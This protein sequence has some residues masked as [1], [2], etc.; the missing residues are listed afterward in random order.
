MAPGILVDFGRG[1]R[2]IGIEI[3]APDRATVAAINRILKEL[4]QPLLKSRDL[5]PLHAA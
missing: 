4:G 3:T 2:P 1:G 5:S